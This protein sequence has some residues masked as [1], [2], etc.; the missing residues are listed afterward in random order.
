MRDEDASVL[1][2]SIASFAAFENAM[3]LDISMGGST[4][5]VLHL[6]AASHEGEVGFTMDDIDRLSRKV[7]VLC[8]V[9][10]AKRT[11]TWKTCTAPAASSEFL[12][13]WTAPG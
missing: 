2:R 10:P 11:S 6:L 5:T 12:A 4:N 3:T 1:P 13:S 8:K 9:A 7:P